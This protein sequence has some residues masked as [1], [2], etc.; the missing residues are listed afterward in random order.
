M[1]QKDIALIAILSIISGVA[2]FLMSQMFFASTDDK[3]QKAEV[4]DVISS[5][6]ADPPKQ[7]FNDTSINPTTVIQIGDNNNTNPFKDKQ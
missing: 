1:K 6:F 2:A 3:Q 4:V 7:Y 5:E